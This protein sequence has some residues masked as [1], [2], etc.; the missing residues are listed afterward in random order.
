MKK[1]LI[2]LTTGLGATLFTIWTFL[3]YI[4]DWLGRGIAVHD[5]HEK[6]A[7]WINGILSWLLGTP[8][9]VPGVL[10]TLLTL[11]LLYSLFKSQ[12]SNHNPSN[13][14][15]RFAPTIRNKSAAIKADGVTD[16]DVSNNTIIGF[17]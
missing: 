10:A 3:K 12:K 15:E 2:Q 5:T 4:V 9:W 1:T 11:A 16:L 13:N 14:G 6:G 7:E 17:E 8:S